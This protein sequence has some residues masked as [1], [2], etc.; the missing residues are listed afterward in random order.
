[1]KKKTGY[2]LIVVGK[3][4]NSHWERL[5]FGSPAKEICDETKIPTLLI[6]CGDEL[7]SWNPTGIMVSASL[8]NS[9]ENAE[10]LGAHIAIKFAADLTI[11]HVIDKNAQQFSNNFTH[12]FPIDYIPPQNATQSVDELVRETEERIGEIIRDLKQAVPLQEIKTH[13]EVGQVAESV[14]E[15][16]KSS[17]K[18]NLLIIG[19][20]GENALKRFFL[21]CNT[22]A[23]EESCRIPILIVF[24]PNT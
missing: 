14:M 2:D 15:Y 11:M 23:I 13:I 21:G 1:M 12:I 3:Q 19:S 10:L 20:R 22:D 6:P 5:L 8:S 4:N 18:N 24:Y 16:L 9:K 17:P 7:K